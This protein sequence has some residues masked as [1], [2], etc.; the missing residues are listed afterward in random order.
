MASY[1]G[2]VGPPA[3]LTT[4]HRP[5]TFSDRVAFSVTNSGVSGAHTT[6]AIAD[7]G[8]TFVAVSSTGNTC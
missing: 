8:L 4:R 7:D 1:L 6:G 5:R 3:D 2:F